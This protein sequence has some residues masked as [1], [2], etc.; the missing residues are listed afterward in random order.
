MRQCLFSFRFSAL[1][2]YYR[3]EHSSLCSP[4]GPCWLFCMH[5]Y[6]SPKLL[7]YP[8]PVFPVGD[9]KFIFC[10]CEFISAFCV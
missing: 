7:I 8:S 4:V 1:K 3:I 5:V 6:V 10:V 9:R 2:G